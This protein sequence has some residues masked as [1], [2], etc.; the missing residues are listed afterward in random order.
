[1]KIRR[2]FWPILLSQ[3]CFAQHERNNVHLRIFFAHLSQQVL[4]G[5]EIANVECVSRFQDSGEFPDLVFWVGKAGGERGWGNRG[6]IRDVTQGAKFL[7]CF[8]GELR[9]G[10]GFRERIFS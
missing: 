3:G 10:L 7:R 6:A 1:M 9:R 5:C 2:R 8:G 4:T